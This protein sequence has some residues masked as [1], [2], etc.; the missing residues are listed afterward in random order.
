MHDCV[1]TEKFTGQRAIIVESGISATQVLEEISLVA[2]TLWVTRT[3]PKWVERLSPPE[4]LRSLA[5]AEER[6]RSGRA[7][8]SVVRVTDMHHTPWPR[9]SDA[10]GVLVRHPMFTRIEAD[11][12]R[13]PDG[14]FERADLIPWATGFRA[15][16]RH[17]A[18]LRLRTP[19]GGDP[20]R[21][22]ALGTTLIAADR[23]DPVEILPFLLLDTT[24]GVRLL[25]VGYGLA[26]LRTGFMA[27]RR[28]QIVLDEPEPEPELETE[29][30]SE[31]EAASTSTATQPHVARGVLT[32]W[33]RLSP[34]HFGARRDHTHP[35]TRNRWSGPRLGNIDAC[36]AP[37]SLPRCRVGGDQRGRTEAAGA[38]H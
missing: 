5:A 19:E 29:T 35:P 37:C 24:F 21:E 20:R 7:P 38:H 36:R 13:M 2:D 8:T 4:I 14:S 33:L 10:R 11:G 3:E 23:M 15:D 28:I 26:G 12:V 17:L 9:R 25:G 31:T 32:C 30:E 27:A 34:R 6:V 18:P 1:S 16:L 22:R